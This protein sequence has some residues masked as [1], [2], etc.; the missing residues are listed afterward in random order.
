MA[1]HFLDLLET[2]VKRL[3]FFSDSVAGNFLIL[4]ENLV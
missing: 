2:T 1:F 4:I 3:P